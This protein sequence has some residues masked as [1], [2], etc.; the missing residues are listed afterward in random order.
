VKV[1]A[2]MIS[3]DETEIMSAEGVNLEKMRIV[4]KGA[5]TL[6]MKLNNVEEE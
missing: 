6:W 5:Y 4:S 2:G 3:G 1:V